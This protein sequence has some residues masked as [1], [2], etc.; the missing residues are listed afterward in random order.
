MNEMIRYSLNTLEEAN[1]Y[2]DQKRAQGY[3]QVSVKPLL[4][5]GEHVGYSVF[6]KKE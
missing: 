4:Y 5:K 2:A 6:W 1:E 3:E